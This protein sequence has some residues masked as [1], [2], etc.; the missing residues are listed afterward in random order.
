MCSICHLV[1]LVLW[2]LTPLPTIFQLYRGDQFYWWRKPV[3]PEKTTDLSQVTDKLNHIM[4]FRVHLD[5]MGFDLTTLV[6]IGTYWIGSLNLTTIRSRPRRLLCY[7]VSSG[8]CI[9]RNM[10]GWI[11]GEA[12]PAPPPLLKLEKIWFFGVK[13]WFFTRNTP[14]IF[15]PPS[16]R[17]KFF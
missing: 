2:C 7:L 4:L 3:Y 6:V 16:A 13:S 1:W 8:L 9:H 10:Q 14:T 15:E 17:R 11:Q 12:H 5:W